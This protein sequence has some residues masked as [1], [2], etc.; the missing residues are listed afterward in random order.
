[1]LFQNEYYPNVLRNVSPLVHSH[2]ETIP[3]FIIAYNLCNV[4][5]IQLF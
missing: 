1:M 2:Q 3:F 5:H 4:K